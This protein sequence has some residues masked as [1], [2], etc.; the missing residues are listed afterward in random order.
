LFM[1]ED[2]VREP[3]WSNV[4]TLSRWLQT[5]PA[6]AA[7]RRALLL[8][9]M[10]TVG[11]ATYLRRV[12]EENRHHWALSR[13]PAA[14]K[15]NPG[16]KS[17]SQPAGQLLSASSV[18]VVNA[19]ER[20][21]EAVSSLLLGFIK[22]GMSTDDS[23]VPDA[24][25]KMDGWESTVLAPSS[26]LR[27]RVVDA[28]VRMPKYTK[29]Y[30]GDGGG[31][32]KL[33][34]DGAMLNHPQH[35]RDGLLSAM[36]L[37]SEIATGTDVKLVFLLVSLGITLQHWDGLDNNVRDVWQRS[38]T[39][40]DRKQQLSRILQ[41]MI[42]RPTSDFFAPGSTT[43][44]VLSFTDIDDCARYATEAIRMLSTAP[45]TQKKINSLFDYYLKMSPAASWVGLFKGAET[46][47]CAL[48][49]VNAPLLARANCRMPR[50]C[51]RFA[52]AHRPF[53]SS[54]W[55][56]RTLRRLMSH[57]AAPTRTTRFSTS[58]SA[59]S[60]LCSRSRSSTVTR[61]N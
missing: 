10:R 2:E 50:P 53:S 15:V 51:I 13:T 22:V 29:I 19:F 28:I 11:F 37:P 32:V 16:E 26:P 54:T 35:F 60:R 31:F 61:C 40:E 47:V 45:E 57:F 1:F 52:A 5:E 14:G 4:T 17:M 18:D 8:E 44:A 25:T 36:C 24:L 6:Q 41:R 20:P 9:L 7:P 12:Y 33:M 39:A 59:A 30:A 27:A 49:C 56:V 21:P 55:T 23:V 58:S 48:M 43:K 42:R 46:I 3:G 38:C 34:R